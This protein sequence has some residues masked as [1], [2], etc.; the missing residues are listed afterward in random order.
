MRILR[1]QARRIQ[2]LFGSR[3]HPVILRQHAPTHYACGINQKLGWP[4][5]VMT[6][7]TLALMDQI[8][9][10]NRLKIRIRKKS[11]RVSGFLTKIT[12]HFRTVYANRDRANSDFVEPG[13][14]LLDAPQLGVA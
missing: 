12:G 6:I 5:D 3:S 13:E 2:Y 8:V 7:L 10:R 4:R 11:K 1:K 14:I 9:F